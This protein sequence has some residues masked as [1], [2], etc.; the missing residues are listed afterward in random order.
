MFCFAFQ[1]D[2]LLEK[3]KNKLK[4]FFCVVIVIVVMGETKLFKN[5]DKPIASQ[6]L[7]TVSRAQLF[8]RWW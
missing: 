6:L 7:F 8:A 2:F 1:L 3:A 4:I 5:L